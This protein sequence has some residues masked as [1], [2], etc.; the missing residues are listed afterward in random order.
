M[1]LSCVRRTLVLGGGGR[2]ELTWGE[3]PV[4][5]RGTGTACGRTAGDCGGP[6]RGGPEASLLHTN[7]LRGGRGRT[8]SVAMFHLYNVVGV[9]VMVELVAM[10]AVLDTH[11]NPIW[12]CDVSMAIAVVKRTSF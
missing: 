12:N 8:V 10:R 3:P 1:A 9:S 11:T 5:C 7:G 4:H 2:V 6:R